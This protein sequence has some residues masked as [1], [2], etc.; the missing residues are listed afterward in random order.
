[1]MIKDFRAGV[2]SELG[3]VKDVL[4]RGGPKLELFGDI[5]N[6]RC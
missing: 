5:P 2:I 1:M 3:H 6:K 4:K